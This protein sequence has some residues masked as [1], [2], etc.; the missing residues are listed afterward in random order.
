MLR[1]GCPDNGSGPGAR[2]SRP[3]VLAGC[4]PMPET[5]APSARRPRLRRE[6]GQIGPEPGARPFELHRLH[7]G[8]QLRAGAGGVR[9]AQPAQV[10]E[11]VAEAGDTPVQ[12]DHGAGRV[13]PPRRAQGSQARHHLV[14]RPGRPRCRAGAARPPGRTAAGCRSWCLR[15]PAADRCRTGGCPARGRRRAPAGS[16]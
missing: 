7:P 8:P 16:S 1:V 5:S 12:L 14:D 13:R 2:T 4:P 15:P 6:A 11:R 10:D 3:T 9:G